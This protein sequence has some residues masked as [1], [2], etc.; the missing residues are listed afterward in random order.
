MT[1][2]EKECG[3]IAQHF[4]WNEIQSLLAVSGTTRNLPARYCISPASPVEVVIRS[5]VTRERNL[6]PMRWGFVSPDWKNKSNK[7]S[8]STMVRIE[9]ATGPKWYQQVA[10]TRHC[11]VPVSGFFK[12]STNGNGNQLNFFS[13]ANDLPILACAALWDFGQKSTEGVSSNA[14]AM[15]VS[16]HSNWSPPCNVPMPILLNADQIDTWLDGR[17]DVSRLYPVNEES[18]RKKLSWVQTR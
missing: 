3:L 11:I 7:L 16:E 13:E 8:V 4:T 10:Q 17:L 5:A 9:E 12:K 6:V 2:R 18:L 14:C 1:A 15:I